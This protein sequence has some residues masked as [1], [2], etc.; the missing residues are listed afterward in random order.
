MDA[1]G[2]HATFLFPLKA[3]FS[4][5]ELPPEPLES[6]TRFRDDPEMLTL[7]LMAILS[8]APSIPPPTTEV[9]GEIS[10]T[11]PAGW[12][13]ERNEKGP[14]LRRSVKAPDQT[15]SCDIVVVVG[16]C[17]H[18]DSEVDTFLAQGREAYMGRSDKKA[19]LKTPAAQFRGFSIVGSKALEPFGKAGMPTTEMYAARIGNDLVSAQFSTFAAS[20]K[21]SALRDTCM[22]II[23]SIASTK[24]R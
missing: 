16:V 3:R 10:F 17:D 2:S 20:P 9:A 13:V 5:G 14:F 24:R 21:A 6:P 15:L 18:D 12:T 11:I 19:D 22:S 7:G 8:G 23:R 1:S 4:L